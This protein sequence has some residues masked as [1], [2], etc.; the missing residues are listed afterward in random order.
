[1]E[2]I[3]NSFTVV[4]LETTGLDI[5]KNKITEIG[6][7]KVVDGKI[8]DTFER[9]V[10]PGRL[11]DERIV[12]LTGIT[13]EELSKAP[14]I[15]EV[16]KDFLAFETTGCLVGHSILFDFSFLK[17]AAVNAGF[18]FEKQGM[19]TLAISRKYL[20]DL[21]SRSL[22][23]LCKHFEIPHQPH[24]ALSDVE[25]TLDLFRILEEKFLTEETV[26]DFSPKP[27]IFNI[28]KESPIQK[29]QIEQLNRFIK[30]YQVENPYDIASLTKNEASRYIDQLISQYGRIP[31]LSR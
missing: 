5:K 27:L 31:P 30:Y 11:L 10:N 23:F 12:E 1:M 8:V 16:I 22:P 15:D 4:D 3:C 18:S 13:D 19:D 6:A 2:K 17:K 7:I 24:R 28:K 26:S 9:L 20:A 14:Y 21:E 29:K 25:A